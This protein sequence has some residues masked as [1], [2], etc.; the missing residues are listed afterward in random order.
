MIV[1]E[2]HQLT[3]FIPLIITTDFTAILVVIL[4]K[5]LRFVLLDSIKFFV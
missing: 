3:V 4:Q 5:W 2:Y 1:F